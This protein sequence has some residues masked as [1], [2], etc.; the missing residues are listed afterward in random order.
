MTMSGPDFIFLACRGKRIG[1]EAVIGAI[2]DL[3]AEL[4]KERQDE[5]HRRGCVVR[6]L[7]LLVIKDAPEKTAAGL[8]TA[9]TESKGTF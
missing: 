1:F 7:I 4:K 2:D 3:V 9:I 6:F 8:G 5:E